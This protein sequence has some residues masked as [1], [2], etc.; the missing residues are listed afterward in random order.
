MEAKLSHDVVVEALPVRVCRDP[1]QFQLSWEITRTAAG[2]ATIA[3][4][5]VM[6][7]SAALGVSA[8]GFPDGAMRR[9]GLGP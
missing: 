9:R 1:G 6:S 2:I 3:Q 8:P 4:R 7:R 5:P